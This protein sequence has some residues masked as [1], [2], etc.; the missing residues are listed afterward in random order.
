M[1][2]VRNVC[3][4]A[5]RASSRARRAQAGSRCSSGGTI[6][7]CFAANSILGRWGAPVGDSMFV[8]AVSVS[9]RRECFGATTLKECR[10]RLRIGCVERTK[11]AH[12]QVPTGLPQPPVYVRIWR[13]GSREMPR[14]VKNCVQKMSQ[15]VGVAR[16]SNGCRSFRRSATCHTERVVRVSTNERA[17]RQEA[18]AASL[19]IA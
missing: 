2:G 1:H 16:L 4:S 14:L 3:A 5:A 18:R 19:A 12:S 13:H 9:A 8:G 11:T 10:H 7:V 15:K 6:R 17:H